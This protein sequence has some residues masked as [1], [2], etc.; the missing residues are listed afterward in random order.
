MS[1]EPKACRVEY[2]T[3]VRQLRGRPVEECQRMTVAACCDGMVAA[4]GD[5]VVSFGE[6]TPESCAPDREGVCRRNILPGL[7]IFAAS[8]DGCCEGLTYFEDG[9]DFCP[10]C[11]AKIECVE[12]ERLE[13]R[14]RTETATVEREVVEEVPVE[15]EKP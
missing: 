9:I 1:D 13:V 2:R 15:V 5:G 3:R 12:A 8:S 11:G 10:F 14:V 7:F 6:N 4:L